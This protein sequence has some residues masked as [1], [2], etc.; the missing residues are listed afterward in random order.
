MAAVVLSVYYARNR[1]QGKAATIYID[2]NAALAAIVNGDSTSIAD[3][4]LI[5][6]L[7]YI[8][9][10]S[11]I[12]I[13]PERVESARNIADPPTRKKKPPFPT[14]ES[15]LSPRVVEAMQFTTRSLTLDR[16]NR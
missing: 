7:W 2:N 6:T 12:A 16:K 1:F 15:L 14:L 4:C 8:D 10:A 3:Y 9:A 11:D 13:W 5:A